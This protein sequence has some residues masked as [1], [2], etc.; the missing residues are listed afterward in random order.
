MGMFT[1]AL[2]TISKGRNKTNVHQGKKKKS[3]WETSS[4]GTRPRK[5]APFR[6]ALLAP[7]VRP[8][9][10]GLDETPW[11]RGGE[12][13]R[14]PFGP[15]AVG[16]RGGGGRTKGRA[17][18]AAGR[19]VPPRRAPSPSHHGKSPAS[20]FAPGRVRGGGLGARVGA[21]KEGQ[22]TRPLGTWA[23]GGGA[24]RLP[25]RTTFFTRWPPDGIKPVSVA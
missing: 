23:A 14:P 15:Q 2:F 9:R 21:G 3:Q 16:G 1:A 13:R 8:G 4:K 10:P 5:G 19:T 22:R 25:L 6:W 24:P 20:R 17:A 12:R 7:R 18:R 11:E